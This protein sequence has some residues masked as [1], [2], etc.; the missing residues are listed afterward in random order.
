MAPLV[1][2][3]IIKLGDAGDKYNLCE[4]F[5]EEERKSDRESGEKEGKGDLE[6]FISHNW[7]DLATLGDKSSESLWKN[8]EFVSL[9]NDVLTPPP[10]FI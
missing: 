1:F 3:S 10:E 2:T 8:K 6:E 9:G 7:H 4:N 5:P